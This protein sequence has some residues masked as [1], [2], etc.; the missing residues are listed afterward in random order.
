[1][2]TDII[3]VIST[4]NLLHDN[5]LDVFTDGRWWPRRWF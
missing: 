3:A 4:V 2:P 5:N 1:M